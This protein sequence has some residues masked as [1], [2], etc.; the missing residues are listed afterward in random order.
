MAPTEFSIRLQVGITGGFAP[1]SPSAIHTI[2]RSSSSPTMD[3]NSQ[4]RAEG[5]HDLRPQPTKTLPVQ[6]HSENL[7]YIYNTLKELPVEDPPGSEDIYGLDTGVNWNGEGLKWSNGGPEGCGSDFS[8]V[9][10]GKGEK[11]KFGEVVKLILEIA[12]AS[13]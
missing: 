4:Q 10:A 8:N 7:D 6:T 11:E 3:I 2:S 9:Q 5:S 13:E 1:P 12:N